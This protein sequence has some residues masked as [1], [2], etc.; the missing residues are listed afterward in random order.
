MELPTLL[1]RF[2]QEILS[3]K[4]IGTF[5]RALDVEYLDE[6]AI[7]GEPIP[8]ADK[9]YVRGT[10]T[11]HIPAPANDASS[12]S[13]EPVFQL[14][15]LDIEFPRG[16][17]SLIAGRFGSGKTLL[18]LSLL[19]E[20]RLVDGKISY[21][22]SHMMDPSDSS[23]PDW[24]IKKDGVAYVPQVSEIAIPGTTTC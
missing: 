3:A 10:V 17:I 14:C 20:A 16:Q 15:D 4:R 8:E 13:A 23:V 1:A 18:L 2:L 22:L 5:L 9:I 24:T 12:S 11:W 21:L 6:P 7:D 19:G